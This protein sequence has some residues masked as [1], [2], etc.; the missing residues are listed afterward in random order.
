VT[1][2]V[3]TVSVVSA[4]VGAVTGSAALVIFQN[5]RPRRVRK[6]FR[7]V[8]YRIAMWW[9]RNYGYIPRW[10]RAQDW[11]PAPWWRT[12]PYWLQSLPDDWPPDGRGPRD[13]LGRPLRPC[14]AGIIPYGDA[15]TYQLIEGRRWVGVH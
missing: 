13:L 9:T 7:W 14:C 4:V 11:Q 6:A 10:S 2:S 15:E 3:L 1:N 12:G 8:I 5:I